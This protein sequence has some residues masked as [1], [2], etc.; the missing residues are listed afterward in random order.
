MKWECKH[1]FLLSAD[2]KRCNGSPYCFYQFGNV[3]GRNPQTEHAFWGCLGCVLGNKKLTVNPPTNR[4]CSNCQAEY[5]RDI[6]HGGFEN[7]ICIKCSKTF[8]T[9][10]TNK[11]REANNVCVSCGTD[12]A[13]AVIRIM[14]PGALSYW[15]TSDFIKDGWEGTHRWVCAD[16][17]CFEANRSI[18]V[19]CGGIDIYRNPKK[20]R[21]G[22]PRSTGRPIVP[23]AD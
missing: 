5:R 6:G 9:P 4:F 8:G 14:G 10:I 13:R 22:L 7:I 16:P 15:V 23:M 2:V 3:F 1:G 20:P 21:C 12:F 18:K 17:A 11:L 19:T